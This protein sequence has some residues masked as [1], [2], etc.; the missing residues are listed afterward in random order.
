[1]TMKVFMCCSPEISISQ[2]YPSR[3]FVT[4]PLCRRALGKRPP[5]AHQSFFHCW[6]P[7][8]STEKGR[9]PDHSHLERPHLIASRLKAETFPR[10]RQNLFHAVL[11]HRAHDKP[12]RRE[13]NS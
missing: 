8:L 6:L 2:T 3:T 10:S 7:D 1:M 9:R 5:L 13:G 12:L 4:P 11:R